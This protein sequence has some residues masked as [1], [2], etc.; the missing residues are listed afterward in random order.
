MEEN[1]VPNPGP[2]NV[3]GEQKPKKKK[4]MGPVKGT[5]VA[6]LLAIIVI[7]IGFLVRMVIAGDGDYLKP[8]KDIFGIE[9]EDEDEDKKASVSRRDD[10][11]V[12]PPVQAAGRYALLSDSV[13]GSNVKHYRLTVDV[14]EFF[15]TIKEYLP[16]IVDYDEN[17]WHYEEN[18]KEYWLD[19]SD[20][21]WD[22]SYDDNNYN[23]DYDDYDY[24]DWDWDY[25]YDD[26]DDFYN[27]NEPAA[28]SEGFDAIG[29]NLESMLDVGMTFLELMG[30]LFDGEMY[31]DIYFEGNE[32]VQ[33][34]VGYDYMEFLENMYGYML[35]NNEEEIDDEEISSVSD[36][37]KLVV[38]EFDE[39]L[40]K[41]KLY[42]MFAEDEE[43]EASLKEMGIREKDVKD[44][45]DFVNDEGLVEV[46]LNGTTKVKAL[47]SMV[48]ESESMKDE[49][50]EMEKETGVKLDED[51]I[52][53]SVLKA[54]NKSDGYKELGFKFVE[55]R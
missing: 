18:G 15:K 2:F 48:L 25:D 44:A 34:V 9:D 31:F 43:F 54:A 24:S 32:I 28:I 10:V 27:Y 33:V 29:S 41:D 42:D 51:N 53:E 49:L 39:I 38:K 4:S 6:L 20:S 3:T 37:A 14:G 35:E 13:E 55:V 45:I 23:Y 26:S 30:D 22:W 52:I 16:S 40:D 8:I 36:L 7:A 50:E 46:Y 17:D 5:L 11:V 1:Q 12:T 19:D 47:L 21:D